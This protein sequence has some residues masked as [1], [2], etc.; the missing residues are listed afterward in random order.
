M[1]LPC[2][3]VNNARLGLEAGRRPPWPS[4]A[5]R[6][7]F[8]PEVAG[9]SGAGRTLWVP[10]VGCMRPAEKDRSMAARCALPLLRAAARFRRDRR[11][12]E[13]LR[14]HVP[15]HG[16]LRQRTRLTVH[17]Q[18]DAAGRERARRELPPARRQHRITRGV[19]G[20]THDHA[21]DASGPRMTPKN[22]AWRTNVTAVRGSATL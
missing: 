17:V 1:R 20:G 8:S 2:H 6:A 22:T 9:S 13:C 12:R 11:Q 7:V 4:C 14:R 16:A 18:H 19:G 15:V 3:R 10:Q 5:L 21:A